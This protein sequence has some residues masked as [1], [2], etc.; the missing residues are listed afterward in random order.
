MTFYKYITRFRRTFKDEARRIKRERLIAW[1]KQGSIVKIHRPTNLSRARS[2]GYKPKQGVVLIRVKVP[3]GGRRKSR[4]TKGRRS[5]RMGVNRITGKISRQT[6]AENRAA[7]KFKNLEVLNS[8]WVGSDGK[9]HYFEV[10]MIDPFHPV[11]QA[12][13][14]YNWLSPDPN[15]E[16]H[17]QKARHKGR[18][19]RGL[20]SSAR[21]S[22]GLRNKGKGAERFRKARRR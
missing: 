8:Y 11:I 2:L 12:D 19:L 20:T 5:K 1:R 15:R 21:K 7:R 3:R 17:R 22:R 9:S 18:S 14:N 16:S 4:P 6:M 13:K 10:I